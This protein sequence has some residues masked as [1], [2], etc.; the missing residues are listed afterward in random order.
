MRSE[1]VVIS[2]QMQWTCVM[3]LMSLEAIECRPSLLTISSDGRTAGLSMARLLVVF[4][5]RWVI[6]LVREEKTNQSQRWNHELGYWYQTVSCLLFTSTRLPGGTRIGSCESS[7][8]KLNSHSTRR[9]KSHHFL[10]LLSTTCI[11]FENPRGEFRISWFFQFINKQTKKAPL[12]AISS[13]I[14]WSSV[15][16]MIKEWS[17]E[18]YI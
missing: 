2:Y 4:P 11:L 16:V 8:S 12:W 5:I 6:G 10:T 1:A 3:E 7:R 18:Q 15:C 17:Y 9:S 14:S 13:G